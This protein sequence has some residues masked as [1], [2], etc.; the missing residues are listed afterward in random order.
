MAPDTGGG[1]GGGVGG[2][3]SAGSLEDFAKK[4]G[5]RMENGIM[6]I[7]PP[8]LLSAGVNSTNVGPSSRRVVTLSGP[9]T[10]MRIMGKFY[11]E[12]DDMQQ[13]LNPGEELG[14]IRVL[15]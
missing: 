8:K 6:M 9:A 2:G 3:G 12:Q 13:G 7:T 11:M 4:H 14:I 15:G 5:G 10:V 1:S